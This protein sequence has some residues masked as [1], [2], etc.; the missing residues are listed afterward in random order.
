MTQT[1]YV[2]KCRDTG[3]YLWSW[4]DGEG[5]WLSTE[6]DKAMRSDDPKKYRNMLRKKSPAANA[7]IVKVEVTTTETVVPEMYGSHSRK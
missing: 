3:R 7:D 2:A 6:P 1:Y 5:T 4:G